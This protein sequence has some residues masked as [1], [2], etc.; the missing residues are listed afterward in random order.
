MPS[1]GKKIFAV[2][3]KELKFGYPNF[4]YI[5]KEHRHFI[6]LNLMKVVPTTSIGWHYNFFKER[7]TKN[8]K[9]EMQN[10]NY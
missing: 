5:M 2:K 3:D 9:G 6:L 1:R 8:T 7:Y 10:E 4:Q